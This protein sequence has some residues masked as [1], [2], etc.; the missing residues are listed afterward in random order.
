MLQYG[1]RRFLMLVGTP[2]VRITPDPTN[3]LKVLHM[4]ARTHIHMT[5]PVSIYIHIYIYVYI[6]ILYIY[7]CIHVQIH[8]Y[9]CI[10]MTL[11]LFGCKHIRKYMYKYDIAV[12]W[13]QAYLQVY[14][15]VAVIFGKH[16]PK[17]LRRCCKKHSS[18]SRPNN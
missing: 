15:Y 6:Y 1:K 14:T 10:N 11:Q 9:T 8:A 5:K 18:Y 12:V 3:S 13:L 4:H 2:S 7:T 16:L 17:S